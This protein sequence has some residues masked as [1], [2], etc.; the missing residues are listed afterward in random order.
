MARSAWAPRGGWWAP[1]A[2]DQGPLVA[3][4]SPTTLSSST[5]LFF[6]RLLPSPASTRSLSL[7]TPLFTLLFY[8]LFQLR[9][10][11]LCI[12][13]S[14]RIKSDPLILHFSFSPLSSPKEDALVV[15]QFC[16]WNGVGLAER[17]GCGSEFS[18]LCLRQQ[19]FSK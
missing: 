1:W 6:I 4:P 12:R 11:P 17:T 8:S 18:P 7:S 13:T 2:F 3:A 10:P 5:P 19:A 15:V 16:R 14:H 9:R